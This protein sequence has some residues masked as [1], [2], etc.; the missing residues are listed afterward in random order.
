MFISSMF[1]PLTGLVIFMQN[2][3][4][5]NRLFMKIENEF[6]FILFIFLSFLNKKKD[7][8]KV[9]MLISLYAQL[10][11]FWDKMSVHFNSIRC[12]ERNSTDRTTFRY[13]KRIFAFISQP[14]F[15]FVPFFNRIEF[16]WTDIWAQYANWVHYLDVSMWYEI[17]TDEKVK[18]TMVM[19]W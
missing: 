9:F 5:R 15:V 8:S 11:T 12:R 3:H 7:V 19:W 4:V 14:S 18:V 10:T 2:V 13:V 6:F 1:L 17:C 16:K